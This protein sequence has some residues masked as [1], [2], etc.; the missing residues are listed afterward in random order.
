MAKTYSALPSDLVG[1][2]RGSV[3]AWE[4]N[5]ATAIFCNALTDELEGV[6]GKSKAAIEMRRKQILD[7]WL[8]APGSGDSVPKGQFKDPA[9]RVKE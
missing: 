7:S 6:E 3:E 8:A 5:Q 2:P 9:A 1:L 4:L